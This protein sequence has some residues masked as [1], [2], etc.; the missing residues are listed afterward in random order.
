M[1]FRRKIKEEE[2][3]FFFFFFRAAFGGER[4]FFFFR[5]NGARKEASD[6][7]VVASDR[8]SRAANSSAFSALQAKFLPRPSITIVVEESP[9]LLDGGVPFHKSAEALTS[10]R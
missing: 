6:R 4:S 1:L 10:D 7:S 5:D 8:L 3:G 9:I 2:K